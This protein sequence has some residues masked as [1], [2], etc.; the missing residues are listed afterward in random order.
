MATANFGNS[1]HGTKTGSLQVYV[2]HDCSAEDLGPS[3]FALDDVHCIAMLDI[4]LCN[5]VSCQHTAYNI[6]FLL[7]LLGV[8]QSYI[9]YFEVHVFKF[10]GVA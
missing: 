1:S 3:L 6:P 2:H 4:R 10:M 8:R 9:L 5:Q 7:P